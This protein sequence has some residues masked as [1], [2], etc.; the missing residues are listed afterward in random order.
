MSELLRKDTVFY[1]NWFRKILK[2]APIEIEQVDLVK[3]LQ[4]SGAKKIVLFTAPE[5]NLYPVWEKTMHYAR[6]LNYC[7]KNNVERHIILNMELTEYSDR[8][9]RNFNCYS[10]PTYFL[11]YT[12]SKLQFFEKDF[13]LYRD[14]S[15]LDKLYIFKN[16][17]VRWHRARAM[18]LLCHN[19]L[20]DHGYISWHGVESNCEYKFDF[21]K[22]QTMLLDSGFATGIKAIKEFH[23]PEESDRSLIELVSETRTDC[24]FITEKTFAA[25]FYRKPFIIIGYK[26]IHQTLK[27]LGF[28]LFEE[29]FEYTFDQLDSEEQRIQG[30]VRNI[31]RLR[32]ENYNSIRSMLEQKIEHNYQNALRIV[33]DKSYIPDIMFKET[34]FE[35][36]KNR[37]IDND[38]HLNFV[39]NICKYY[40]Q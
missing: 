6:F 20:L 3:G 22:E 1:S 9:K 35:D 40:T 14:Y 29:I 23:Y 30:V 15:N 18:D 11:Y 8:F 28:E 36:Y 13:N 24:K 5:I 12:Y 34:G 33:H 16:N 25:L 31:D 4:Q 32:Y 2:L 27:D 21:W 39:K 38:F 19:N 17:R 37:P 26:G 10:W 7:T